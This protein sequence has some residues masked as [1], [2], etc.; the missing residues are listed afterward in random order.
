MMLK[1]EVTLLWSR[2]AFVWSCVS[3]RAVKAVFGV[4]IAEWL[5]LEVWKREAVEDW[6]CGTN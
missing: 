4:D 3:D 6:D 1:E 5:D 2:K